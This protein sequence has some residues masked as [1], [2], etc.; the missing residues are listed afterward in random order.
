MG[1]VSVFPYAAAVLYIG[2]A[3]RCSRYKNSC[4][5]LWI[6]WGVFLLFG[7]LFVWGFFNVILGTIPY[8]VERFGLWQY[9]RH[10]LT[11]Y[12]L[13]ENFVLSVLEKLKRCISNMYYIYKLI[14]YN[15]VQSTLFKTNLNIAR[16]FSSI[17]L[18]V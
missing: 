12:R 14:F 11:S 7:F 3:A 5:Q 10:S 17:V 13:Q 15:N 2:F 9:R 6:L 8:N 1:D 18:S 16:L 4:R